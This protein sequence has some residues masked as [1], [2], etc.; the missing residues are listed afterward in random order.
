MASFRMSSCLSIFSGFLGISDYFKYFEIPE[1][2]ST[3]KWKF[4]SNKVQ[5]PLETLDGCT[6]EQN[7]TNCALDNENLA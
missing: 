6:V 1:I 5:K 4:I 3:E 7:S 2:C